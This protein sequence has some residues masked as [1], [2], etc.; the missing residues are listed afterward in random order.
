MSYEQR[1]GDIAIFLETAPKSD[2][3]PLWKGRA[4]IDGVAMEVALWAKGTAGTMLAGQIKPAREGRE[5]PP[6]GTVERVSMA[7]A[8]GAN[9]EID[10]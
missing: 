8:V 2:K 9:D 5:L 3:A 6:E 10:W 4:L 1:E 7:T